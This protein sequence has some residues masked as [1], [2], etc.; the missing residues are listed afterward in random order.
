MNVGKLRDTMQPVISNMAIGLLTLMA[1]TPAYALDK[2]TAIHALP[3]SA[4]YTRTFLAVVA[5]INKRGKGLVE[6]TVR[7]GPDAINKFEQPNAVRDGVVDMAHMPGGLYSAKVPE[8]DAMVAGRVSPMEARANGG[9]VLMDAIHQK[10]FNVKHLGW[11][12]GGVGLHI[13]LTREPGFNLNG[14]L[15]LSSVKLRDDPNYQPF[16]EALRATTLSMPLSDVHSA[17]QTGAVEA[18]AWPSIGVM[19]LKWDAFLKVR[20]DPEF[21]NLDMGILFNLD[22]WNKLS[23]ESRKLIQDVIIEWEQK[24]YDARA[25]QKARE[26]DE[27]KTRGLKFDAMYE[28]GSQRY[29]DLADRVAWTRMKYRLD[30]VGGDNDYDVLRKLY[31]KEVM[32]P[33]GSIPRPPVRR[34]SNPVAR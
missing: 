8:V 3:T 29:Q 31:Y 30:D 17:L 22:S 1:I 20:I 9:A 21:Y 13:Y 25:A 2:V 27:L 16:F 28:A 33:S 14:V 18:V 32:Q 5:D 12:D 23:K 15:D 10:R 19:D 7:G 34:K 24:S 26:A 6:I 4:V 11:I